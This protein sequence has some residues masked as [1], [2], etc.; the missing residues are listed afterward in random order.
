MLA[1][2]LASYVRIRTVKS[3]RFALHWPRARLKRYFSGRTSAHKYITTR[4]VAMKS[5]IVAVLLALA[6]VS[7]SMA[8]DLKEDIVAVEKRSWEAYANHDAK[9][10]GDTITDDAVVVTLGGDILTGKPQ[11]LADVSS[12]SCDLRNFDLA[13]T[14][15]RQPSPDTAVLTYNLTQDITCGGKKLPTKAFATSVYVRQGGK[16]RC[17]NYQETALQ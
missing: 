11:I 10:Y 14:K 16:W 9:A 2:W 4:G 13:D 17:M 12:K 1:C 3:S 8:A 5:S 7:S 15:L 6:V